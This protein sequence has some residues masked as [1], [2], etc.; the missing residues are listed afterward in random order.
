MVDPYIRGTAGVEH[1]G[2]RR[3]IIWDDDWNDKKLSSA[4]WS[5]K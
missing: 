3:P 2:G 1:G 5:N 4:R